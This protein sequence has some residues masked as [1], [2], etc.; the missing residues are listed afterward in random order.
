M[1]DPASVPRGPKPFEDLLKSVGLSEREADAV[2]TVVLDLTAAE[3]APLIGVGGSTV[4][5][6]RQRAYQKLGVATKSEFLRLPACAAW[7]ESL[8]RE[9]A[10]GKGAAPA[11]DTLNSGTRC[12][13]QVSDASESKCQSGGVEHASEKLPCER[14]H[15]L[16]FLFLKCLA[17]SFAMVSAF[18]TLFVLLQPR[19]S[20]LESPN[21]CISSAY[22]DVPNV[23]GM[24]ADNAALALASEG[25][26]PE[27][28]TCAS[29]DAP[30]TAL[31]VAEVGD[32]TE[33]EQ[34]R[35]NVAWK[36]GSVSGYNVSGDWRAFVLIEVAV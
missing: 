13:T 31:C 28:S 11:N 27:F 15:G 4:G 2:R 33:A 35:S 9:R 8:R 14:T 18:V 3:A 34:E 16:A 20:Y 21:G 29:S 10:Y 12:E 1:P 7:R 30:G 5:S 24:R 32:M 25:Y 23:T 22:G 17:V 19:Y 6:Y 26:Y 36:G